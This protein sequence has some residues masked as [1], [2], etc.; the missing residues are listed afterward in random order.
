MAVNLRV[1][2]RPGVRCD[3]RSMKMLIHDFRK[4][5][6]EAGILP[7]YKEHQYFESKSSKARKKR[8][9]CINKMEQDTIERKLAAGEKVQC[10]SKMIKKIRAKQAKQAKAAKRDFRGDRKTY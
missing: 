4:K 7:L 1:E 2:L 10:S 6:N 5:V 9:D 3:D 8:K